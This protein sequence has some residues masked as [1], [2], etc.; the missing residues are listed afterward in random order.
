[1]SLALGIG[2]IRH[3]MVETIGYK[4]GEQGYFKLDVLY[5]YCVFLFICI[6][7]TCKTSSNANHL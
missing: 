4:N 2:N 6:K 1:M 5:I 7:H 3:I